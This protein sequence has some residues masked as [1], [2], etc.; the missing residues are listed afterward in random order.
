MKKQYI[1]WL[2]RLQ[3][4]TALIVNA[5]STP[6]SRWT[7]YDMVPAS[8]VTSPS[9]ACGLYL[10]DRSSRPNNS[11]KIE[12]IVYEV[13]NIY[14][15][16]LD[17]FDDTP[18]ADGSPS[19]YNYK[20]NPRT[21]LQYFC[22]EFV[23]IGQHVSPNEPCWNTVP[24][25][26]PKQKNAPPATS[27]CE[28]T[29][30]GNGASKGDAPSVGNPINIGTGDK[31]LFESD[32]GYGRIN[33]TRYYSDS[34]IGSYSGIGTNWKLTVD[35]WIVIYSTTN[36]Q[37]YRSNGGYYNY[38]INGTTWLPDADITDKLVEL[39]DS[40]GV[41]TGWT[42]TVDSTGEVETYDA[43][44]LL[45]SIKDKAGNTQTLTYSTTSTPT[46][47]APLPDLLI[48][49]TDQLGRSLKFTYDANAR[50]S[51]LITPQGSVISYAYDTNNNLA[52]VTYP[53]GKTKTYHYGETD[54]VSATPSTGVSYTS[55]L[56]GITDENGVRYADYFYDAEGRATSEHLAL[57]ADAASLAFTADA[58]GN[59]VST[60]VTDSRGNVRTYNFTTV[61]GVVKMTGQSQPAG[62]GCN[63]STSAMSYDAHGNVASRSDFNGNKTTYV[64][65][66]VRNLE[67]SRT[68][69]LNTA[70]AATPATR[71]ITTTWHATWRLPLVISEYTGASATGTPLKRTTYV[72]DAKGNITS[73]KEEDPVRA[74]SRT[75][76]TTYTF[77][78]VVPGLVLT[79]VVDGPRT[80]VAD[81]TTYT[82][83]PHDA[84]CDA[85]SAEAMIDPITGTAPA[86]LGCRGQLQ[87]V[88][89]ALGHTT[90]YDRYNHHGQVEQMTDANGIITTNTYDLRQRL[91]S[92]SVGTTYPE[93][94]FLVYDGA[95][96]IIQLIMPY[97]STLNYT[98][99]DAHRL[100]QIQDT[101]GNKVVYTL[102]AQGNRTQETLTDPQGN[103]T[104]TITRSYD[105]LNRLQQVTGV[106]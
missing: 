96:Q 70:G 77:S 71:T 12:K 20:P 27:S 38:N 46:S 102:D 100:I 23:Q 65:D 32:Y 67:T 24:K 16:V 73:F 8:L 79:K 9:A 94:T 62:S 75:T 103:L 92:R 88:S 15:C 49:V 86:N 40:G 36:V 54:H 4:A 43:N 53:D 29:R 59:P 48:Q 74:L 101:L 93:N 76:T 104:K 69:G 78:T 52:S 13:N 83:Y 5:D 89:N 80:D 66:M 91:L 17:C 57:G 3:L 47:I 85:S 68:E 106:E 22:P 51:T 58:N 41:R 35:K 60:A 2:I 61:L 44:G 90:T 1:S 42:Y 82:Y 87:S 30:I 97:G 63:A 19:H 6:V 11:C 55:S 98:Y 18:N 56:T 7:V 105:A 45:L 21:Q 31:F 99:D 50:I 64:Y 28:L 26:N 33:I 95:G 84:V 39:K 72:Y 14:A 10:N 25:L 37:A 34:G 81:V